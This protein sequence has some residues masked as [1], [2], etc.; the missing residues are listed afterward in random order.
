MVLLGGTGLL[1]EVFCLFHREDGR[2]N[3]KVVTVAGNQGDRF[4]SFERSRRE[5]NNTYDARWESETAC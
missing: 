3:H 2:E 5:E 1:P 4:V